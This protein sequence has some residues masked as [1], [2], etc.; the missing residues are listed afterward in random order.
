MRTPIRAVTGNIVWP[1]HGQPWAMWH[2]P[3]RPWLH[4]DE[5]EQVATLDDARAAFGQLRS[6]ALLAGLCQPISAADWAH[7]TNTPHDGDGV[8]AARVDDGA[9][10]WERSYWFAAQIDERPTRLNRIGNPFRAVA[11]DTRVA[12]AVPADQVDRAMNAADTLWTQAFNDPRVRPATAAEVMWYLD[13]TVTRGQYDKPVDSWTASQ[14]GQ[15][16]QS[17]TRTWV[18]FGAGALAGLFDRDVEPRP[19]AGRGERP[20]GRVVRVDDSY[21]A[22]VVVTATPDQWKIEPGQHS[23]GEVFSNLER[24]AAF[25]VDWFCRVEP[26]PYDRVAGKLRSLRRN[27]VEQVEQFDGDGQG[28]NTPASITDAIDGANAEEAELGPQQ[29][30]GLPALILFVVAAPDPA[31]CDERARQVEATM[32]RYNVATVRPLNGQ[33]AALKAQVPTGTLPAIFNDYRQELT[34]LGLAGM[35]PFCGSVVGD[36]EGAPFAV[37]LDTGI[38]TTV[39]L[40]LA[41]QIRQDDDDVDT[42]ASASIAIIGGLG[43]GKSY[44]GKTIGDIV[45]QRGGKF[46]AVD[47]T[48]RQEWAQYAQGLGPDVAEILTIDGGYSFDPFAC[49]PTTQAQQ[50]TIGVLGSFLDL[51]PTSP[52]GALLAAAVRDVATKDDPRIGDVLA[53]LHY[54]GDPKGQHKNAMAFS[55][56][57]RLNVY[58]LEPYCAPLFD[59]SRPGVNLDKQAVVFSLPGLTLPTDEQS[60]SEYM[61]KQT[62]PEQVWGRAVTYLLNFLSRW[63]TFKDDTFALQIVDEAWFMFASPYGRQMLHEAVRDSRKHNN[64]LIILTHDLKEVPEETLDLLGSVLVGRV[65]GGSARRA[66]AL[67]GDGASAESILNKLPKKR[68]VFM[69]RDAQRRTALIQVLRNDRLHAAMDTRPNQPAATREEA[70]V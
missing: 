42:T 31:V 44:T 60:K 24:L 46:T 19:K 32:T 18:E 26:Q 29:E 45:V 41:E 2:I 22:A 39:L 63:V 30:P 48:Q 49:L 23:G 52:E 17:N 12:V 59:R 70:L 6:P 54:W 40:G 61:A 10:M 58:A 1:R 38:H 43:A 67:F 4:T 25:P 36:P 47:R 7:R 27:M 35:A 21:Q 50:G 13:R 57:Q 5:A 28:T 16:R 56:Y 3:A 62:Q 66:A 68:G 64:G 20:L 53:L 11:A 14:F 34:P 69:Y 8:D 33:V 9:A 55:L 65:E 15:T 37:N 51:G